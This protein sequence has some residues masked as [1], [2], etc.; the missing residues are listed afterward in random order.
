M[1]LKSH[2]WLWRRGGRPTC[3]SRSLQGRLEQQ[4]TRCGGE[5]RTT[6]ITTE[7]D[8]VTLSGVLKAFETPRHEGSV[9]RVNCPTQAKSGLEWGT[10]PELELTVQRTLLRT[11]QFPF[12]ESLRTLPCHF[13]DREF[14]RNSNRNIRRH[15]RFFGMLRVFPPTQRKPRR[16]GQP[17]PAALPTG[18]AVY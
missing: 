6:L 8:E 4:P 18:V 9:G 12:W 2:G 3:K 17:R 11:G 7:R 16:V 5:H 10:R 1:A 13:L 15:W 14:S